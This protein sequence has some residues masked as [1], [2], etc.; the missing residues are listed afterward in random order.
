MCQ[1]I[2]V[3]GL[4]TRLPSRFRIYLPLRPKRISEMLSTF[5]FSRV[6]RAIGLFAVMAMLFVGACNNPPAPL[7]VSTTT[8]PAGSSSTGNVYPSTTLV[9]V[10]GTTPYKWAVTTGVLPPG[11]NLNNAGVISGSATTAGTY[12]FKVTVTDTATPANTATGS[13]SITINPALAVT[14]TSPLS[15][16]DAGAA[17]SVTLASTGGVAPVTWAINSGALPAGLSIAPATGIISGTIGGAAAGTYTI[18]VKATDSQS[19]TAISASLTLKVDPPV[20]IVPPVFPRGVVGVS[21]TAPAFGASGGSGTGYT[22]VVVPAGAIAPLTIN[23][24][25]GVISGTPTAAGTL[26]FT[27]K[28]TDSLGFNTTSG[29]LSITINA[30]IVVAITSPAAPV[31][32]EQSGTLSITASVTNDP[33]TAGVTWS[34]IPATGSGTLS[35]ATATTVTYNAPASIAAAST[36]T[37]KATSVTDPTKFANFTVHLVPPPSISPSTVPGGNVGTP[38]SQILTV[39]NGVG[40]YAWS[41][42]AGALPAGVNLIT[43]TPTTSATLSGIPTTAAT[44]SFTVQVI[45]SGNPA[46]TTSV[47]YSNVVIGAM[48]PLSITTSSLPGGSL[49][50]AYGPVQINATGGIAPYSFGVTGGALPAGMVLSSGGSLSGTPTQAG[51]GFSV[52]IT[53]TDSETPTAGTASTTPALSLTITASALI[54]TPG[55][56]NLPDAT[57]NVAYTTSLTPSGG[58]GPYTITLDG[59]SAAMPAGLTFTGTSASTSA[60]TIAGTPTVLATTPGIIVDVTDSEN[61]AVQTQFTYSLAVVLA[62]GSGSENLLSGNYAFMLKGFD[63]GGNPALIGGVF[64]ANGTIGAGSLTSGAVDMNLLGGVQ[65]NLAIVSTSTYTVGSDGRGCMA[66]GITTPTGVVT[67]NYR[68]SLGASGNGHMIDFDA[69][70]PFTTG[71]LR[72]QNTGAFSTAQISGNYAFGTSSLQD[73]SGSKIAAMGVLNLSGGLVT[74][75]SA[76][77]NYYDGSTSP[78]TVK[79]DGVLGATS[80]PTSPLTV[81]TPGGTYT[82]NGTTGR[83]TISFTLSDTSSVNA[84]IYVVS[85][86]EMLMVSSGARSSSVAIF[87]GTAF[88]QSGTF[89]TSSLSG[90]SV[91]YDSKPSNNGTTATSKISIGIV[92]TD[93]AGNFSYAGYS[94]GGGDVQTPSNNGATGTF[95][96]ASNGR[97]TLTVGGTG[98]NQIP[99]FYLFSPGNAFSVSSGNGADDGVMESQS[100]KSVTNGTY[101]NGTINPQTA[102]VTDKESIVTLTTGNATST[103]DS[104][105]QGTLAP[106]HAST[107]TYTVDT[108]GVFFLPASCTPGTNCEKI[109]TVISGSKIVLMDGQSSSSGGTTNPVLQL[110]DQ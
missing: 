5:R 48:L 87:A 1:I 6:S 37:V 72:K 32:L 81:N 100:A 39:S 27:V 108:T 79:L 82:I 25:T 57:Q 93:G 35:A 80:W 20:A 74:G 47:A 84:Y 49:G 53:V 76:D 68:F 9:A 64:T 101:T 95:S 23:S 43:G 34:V 99:V 3:Y 75:G 77:Y 63:S 94:N 98:N 26:S 55:T 13:L 89:S 56:G 29:P 86:N 42:S 12:P 66:M 21:Y 92:T 40:P 4:G 61:P 7:A 16:G 52:T 15:V 31:T 17:Y 8:L 91:F 28:V 2:L 41:I 24:G 67:Q 19:G 30:A 54:L 83:G 109:G 104:N 110:L 38:Y 65:P 103:D 102:G 73:T 105:S 11:L 51:T 59:T 58:V 44:Y 45:D 10:N 78:S 90:T 22:Y 33:N 88:K 62:C 69:A 60:A 97:V 18:T 71:V 107:G 46:Q 106:N 70:G 36:V 50:T 96:V 85:A 14:T